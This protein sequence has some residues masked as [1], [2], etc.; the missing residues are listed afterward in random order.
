[1]I[2]LKI[3]TFVLISSLLKESTQS[4]WRGGAIYWAPSNPSVKFPIN[5]TDVLITQRY[6]NRLYYDDES[7]ASP[8]DIG[9]SIIIQNNGALYSQN[10]PSWVVST[11]SICKDYSIENNWQGGERTTLRRVITTETIH[12][13]FQDGCW[14]NGIFLTNSTNLGCDWFYDI[15]IDLKQRNDTGKINS[16]PQTT[17]G[18]PIFLSTNCSGLQQ[19][20]VTQDQNLK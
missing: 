7:C 19:S 4:H 5:D 3:I 12:A 11:A 1:M 10:G 8:Y 6:A 14:V 18:F 16:S 9:K 20:Y 2:S 17:A 15:F 13:R